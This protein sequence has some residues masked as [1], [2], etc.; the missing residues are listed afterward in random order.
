MAAFGRFVFFA[1]HVASAQRSLDLPWLG[2]NLGA[3]MLTDHPWTNASF[4]AGVLIWSM[5]GEKI[6]ATGQ[7]LYSATGY[8]SWNDPLS[9]R[10]L[11]KLLQLDL[12]M[13]SVR[14]TL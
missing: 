6:P 8:V 2:A 13:H 12:R 14:V 7:P 4:L 9:R 5:R 10:D 1:L 3:A 11:R